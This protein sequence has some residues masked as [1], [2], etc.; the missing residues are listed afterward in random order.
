MCR[1]DPPRREGCT[2]R[3]AGTLGV[4]GEAATRGLVELAP[5]INRLRTTTAMAAG[6]LENSIASRAGSLPLSRERPVQFRQQRS[7]PQEYPRDFDRRFLL[8]QIT[9]NFIQEIESTS[10]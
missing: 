9:F 3:V 6:S 7:A 4:S 8:C 1:P 5:A 10:F 2:P